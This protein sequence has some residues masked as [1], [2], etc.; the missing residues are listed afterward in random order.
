M[1][2]HTHVCVCVN[3]TTGVHAGWSGGTAKP[4][5]KEITDW[6]VVLACSS[7]EFKGNLSNRIRGWNHLEWNHLELTCTCLHHVNLTGLGKVRSPRK[8]RKHLQVSDFTAILDC[9]TINQYHFRVPG[10]VQSVPTQLLE[11]PWSESIQ[12]SS[13][14]SMGLTWFIH[15]LW[16]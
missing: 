16:W 7:L 9:Q 10:S 6:P 4:L 12:K 3:V 1:Y 2:T 5:C 11:L 15:L 13:N 8:S 14:K